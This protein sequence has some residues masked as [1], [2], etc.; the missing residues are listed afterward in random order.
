M[1]WTG[2]SSALISSLAYFCGFETITVI[3]NLLISML[4]C[5]YLTMKKQISNLGARENQAI[6]GAGVFTV[7]LIVI[8][9]FELLSFWVISNTYCMV[10]I[11]LLMI[12]MNLYTTDERENKALLILLSMVICWLTLSRAEMSVCMACIVCLISF[13]PLTQREML[14]LSVPMMVVQLLY[15][16]ELNYQQA[17]SVKNV[18]DSMLTP[19]IQ[20]IITVA[21][22][23]CVIYSFFINSKFFSWIRKKIN[24]IVFAVLPG[25]CIAIYFLDKEKYVKSIESIIY[26]FKTQYWGYLPALI[27]ILYIMIVLNKRINFWLIFSTGYVLI[28]LILCLGRKHPLRN[29]YGDSCNRIMMSA[30]PVVFFSAT[31]LCL[32]KGNLCERQ[33]LIYI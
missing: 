11:F 20:A 13:L 12:G 17:I 25:I 15:L 9:A 16:I 2:V 18:Y 26:N 7:M 10:Y 4:I 1:T 19:A 32:C 30:I 28:N 31:D 23:G 3:H 6:V 14:T 8:P 29:G 24:I 27:L 33:R 22:V 5:F 21:T